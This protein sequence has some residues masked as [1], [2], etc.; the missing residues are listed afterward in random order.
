MMSLSSQK[1]AESDLLICKTT[2]RWI[3][4]MYINYHSL[5]EPN[6]PWGHTLVSVGDSSRIIV[7]WFT[8][9][10]V[11]FKT[12]QMHIKW[13][14]WKII[15]FRI[16]PS[17]PDEKTNLWKCYKIRNLW[18]C[19]EIRKPMKMQWNYAMKV[20][21]KSIFFIEVSNKNTTKL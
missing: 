2:S 1:N 3:N 14:E 8:N 11:R 21:R 17:T 4:A 12:L 7:H 18:K 15:Y 6:I 19:Y 10:T 5:T 13:W 20:L 16:T 9:H